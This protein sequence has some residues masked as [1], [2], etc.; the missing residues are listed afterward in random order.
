[1]NSQPD[2]DNY[3][4]AA[5]AARRGDLDLTLEMAERFLQADPEDARAMQLQGFVYATRGQIQDAIAVLR[6]ANEIAPGNP[7]TLNSLGFLFKQRG[8]LELAKHYL[9]Q[10]AAAAP[11]LFEAH[12]HLADILSDL[13]D[14]P[15]ARASYEK[16]VELAP[17]NADAWGKFARFHERMNELADARRCAERALAIRPNHIAASLALAEVDARE[18]DHEAVIE[19]M[20]K[21]LA[22]SRQ[23]PLNTAAACGTLA[24]ALEKVERYSESFEATSASNAI[25]RAFFSDSISRR[26][27]AHSPAAVERLAAFFANADPR[28][29]TQF[30]HLEGPAPVFLVGFPRSGTT[31]LDQILSSH[32]D[33]AVLEEKRTFNAV[34]NEFVLDENGLARLAGL[35]REEINHRRSAYWERANTW[36]GRPLKERLL[37]DKLP[38]NTAALGIIHRIFPEAKIVFALR[39]PR[40]VV[41]SCYQ[42]TFA[43]NVAMF[44]FLALDDAAR[45]YDLVMRA[46]RVCREKLPIR[47]HEVRYEGVVADMRAE[48][49]PLFEFLGLDW[50]D[51]AERFFETA[52]ARTISTPSAR[53]V[54]Q[55]L[56][57]GSV[58]KW[59]HY[60]EQLAPVLPILD[61]WAAAFGYPSR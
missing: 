60:E 31:L 5:A 6:R 30:D 2:D 7:T 4:I 50:R 10:A 32:D 61:P 38:L 55:P 23:G 40:D 27:S 9:E 15:A 49:E 19:R 18:G 35:T 41:L 21:L 37:V 34:V 47:A 24:R 11:D 59:R 14:T 57:A 36:L 25:R 1:M 8:D 45:Y 53:Q 44:Q 26:S 39:D 3:E 28:S 54:T 51:E 56:Y 33:I 22:E 16:A 52:R 46:G 42:Q 13:G 48:I 20:K 58:G 29:W 12:L 43:M 17:E